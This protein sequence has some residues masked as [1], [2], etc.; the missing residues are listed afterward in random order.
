M[1]ELVDSG[2]QL[3]VAVVSPSRP[4]RQFDQAGSSNGLD[5]YISILVALVVTELVRLCGLA[6]GDVVLSGMAFHLPKLLVSSSF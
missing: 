5:P 3:L 6:C 1:D 4:V 2:H